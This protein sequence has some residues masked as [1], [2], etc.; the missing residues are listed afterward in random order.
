[1]AKL[2]AKLKKIHPFCLQSY[3]QY[4]NKLIIILRKF[5]NNLIL[6]YN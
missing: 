6:C 2:R 3:S 5:I 1:M 4:V